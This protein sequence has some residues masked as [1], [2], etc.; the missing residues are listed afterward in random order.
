MDERGP[1]H[2]GYP[3]RAGHGRRAW[4]AARPL[5]RCL[6]HVSASPGAWAA[7]APGLGRAPAAPAAGPLAP[8][9]P[10]PPSRASRASR[11]LRA[12]H[13]PRRPLAT[14]CPASCTQRP[15]TDKSAIAASNSEGGHAPPSPPITV[16][17]FP[18]YGPHKKPALRPAPL[19]L[20]P[21]VPA[22][23]S[24]SVGVG[25]AARPYCCTRAHPAPCMPCRTLRRFP[26]RAQ[27]HTSVTPPRGSCTH[28]PIA[29]HH[30]SPP[31][32]RAGAA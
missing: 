3:C 22:T 17:G 2:I 1:G 18:P 16:H 26:S 13:L 24:P 20:L 21:P 32:R 29:Q 4:S 6:T 10:H 31:S 28:P 7:S 9:P 30:R 25:L 11:A 14:P 12:A 8:C 23:L 19:G 15:H 5:A 27:T